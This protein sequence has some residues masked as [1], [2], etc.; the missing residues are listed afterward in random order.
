M[1]V[2]R[3]LLD[4]NAVTAFINRRSVFAERVRDARRRGARIGTCEP[5]VAELFYGLEFSLSRDENK[6]R[7]RHALTQIKCWPFDLLRTGS[8]SPL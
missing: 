8:H 6:I 4:S 2:I 1:A 5:V 7:L 3:Y